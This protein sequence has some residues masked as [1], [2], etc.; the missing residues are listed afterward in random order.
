VWTRVRVPLSALNGGQPVIGVKN[1]VIGPNSRA[2]MNVFQLDDIAWV[3]ATNDPTVAPVTNVLPYTP[4]PCT[5][6][7]GTVTPVPGLTQPPPTT[8]RSLTSPPTVPGSTQAPGATPAPGQ[9]TIPPTPAVTLAAS[10]TLNLRF[11]GTAPT[12]AQV[13]AY[14]TAKLQSLG[15]NST[16]VLV[17]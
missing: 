15:M 13:Q 12:M 14:V 1:I 3:P 7:T 2:Q 8:V 6:S 11:N 4:S 5:P 10:L 16:L 17:L 9:S